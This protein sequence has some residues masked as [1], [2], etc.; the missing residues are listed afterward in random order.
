MIFSPIFAIR[1]HYIVLFP[2]LLTFLVVLLP[3]MC[4]LIQNAPE[5]S[6]QGSMAKIM[7][8]HVPS[9]WLSI[10][11]YTVICIFS[12][13]FIVF[14]NLQYYILS[15]KLCNIGIFYTIIT[16]ITGSV[17][18]KAAWGTWWAWD[19]RLTSVLILLFIYCCYKLLLDIKGKNT[20]VIASI[21]CIA[22]FV[23]IPIIKLSV[24]LWNT[25]HQP[26][27]FLRLDGPSIHNAML[28][29]LMLSM[30]WHS[31]FCCLIIIYSANKVHN[32]KKKSDFF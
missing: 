5:D 24:D 19:A 17:W 7:Y 27:S 20:P 16:L 12:V 26:S 13:I 14:K 31:A 32:K 8:I 23:I 6:F 11:I 22:C 21:Y 30:L 3:I 9:A 18:G 29:P 4:F 2:C 25:L 1:K 10:G 15:N 28:Y